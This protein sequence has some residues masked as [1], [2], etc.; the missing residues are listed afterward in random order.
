[1]AHVKVGTFPHADRLSVLYSMFFGALFG[2][3][4]GVWLATKLGRRINL[5]STACNDLGSASAAPLARSS[6]QPAPEDAWTAPD[7]IEVQ[8]VVAGRVIEPEGNFAD[9]ANQGPS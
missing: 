7:V 9:P 4:V 3:A 2:L 1:L 5:T 8:R 6:V